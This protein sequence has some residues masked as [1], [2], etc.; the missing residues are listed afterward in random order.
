MGMRAGSVTRNAIVTGGLLLFLAQAVMATDV[1]L[2]SAESQTGLLELYT[3]EGC[4]SCPPADRWLSTLKARQDLWRRLVPVAFHVDYWDYIG[5][6]D[7][8]ASPAYSGRQQ[9]YVAERSVR[10][11]YTPAFVYNGNEWRNRFDGSEKFPGGANT[12]ALEMDVKARSVEVRFRPI[13]QLEEVQINVALLGFDLTSQIGA[14]E[15][16]GRELRHDFVVLGMTHKPLQLK[17]GSFTGNIE[18]PETTMKAPRHAIAAWVSDTRRQT[19]LQA[20]GGWLPGY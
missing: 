9:R 11:V 17:N 3:S 19:P 10:T 12:G 20:V 5:W 18:L 1:H 6:K 7:R 15:N 8:F 2:R 4:S 16:A 14:G 13:A